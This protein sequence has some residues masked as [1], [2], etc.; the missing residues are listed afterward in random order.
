MPEIKVNIPVM[1]YSVWHVESVAA[2]MK[3]VLVMCLAVTLAAGL[4]QP[5][6]E[7]AYF[8]NEAIRQAQNTHLIPQG[9][10][11]QKVS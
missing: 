7:G 2:M 6:K 10:S 9:A 4:P 8:T 5:Q 1:A 3:V 11:I